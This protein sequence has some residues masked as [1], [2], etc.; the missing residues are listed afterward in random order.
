MGGWTQK[1]R[2]YKLRQSKV[3]NYQDE[4]KY[5]K[6]QIKL[7]CDFC[8]DSLT[9]RYYAKPEGQK[10]NRVH[11]KDETFV[12]LSANSPHYKSLQYSFVVFTKRLV[13]SSTI[14]FRYATNKYYMHITKDCIGEVKYNCS[15]SYKQENQK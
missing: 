10:F 5:H 11:H 12:F 8:H 6:I 1:S 14:M 2:K 7:S 3:I 4:Q 15:I 9:W 13:Y